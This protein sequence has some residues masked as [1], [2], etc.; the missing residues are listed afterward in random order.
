V[1]ASRRTAKRSRRRWIAS[2]AGAVVVSPVVAALA[3][4]GVAFWGVR[5]VEA[6][7][8]FVRIPA[9][10]FQMGSPDTEEERDPNEGPV[11]EVCPKTFELGKFEVTQAEWRRVMIHNRDPST[12][13]GDRKPV[14]SVNWN[15]AQTF[16]SL[17]NIFGQYNYRLP[18]EAEWE[19]AARAGTTTARYWGDRAEDGCACENMA[20]LSLHYRRELR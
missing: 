3:W 2:I 1:T 15:E 5:T 17:M 18:S 8:E 19:Y 6:E 14:E 13:K 9:G 11:H 10:C 20:D 16:I 4:A 7:M 12:Y